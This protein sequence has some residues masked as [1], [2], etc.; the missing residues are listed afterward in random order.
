MQEVNVELTSRHKMY[1]EWQ[2]DTHQY[3]G[4]CTQKGSD[5]Y[6]TYKEQMEGAGEVN[7][8]WKFSQQS[9]SL[10]RQGAIQTKQ[11]FQK[12]ETDRTT[13]HSPHGIFS[14]EINVYKMKRNDENERPSV[15]QISYQLWLNEQYAG[16]H[17]ISLQI[18]WQ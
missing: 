8:V 1:D 6:L 10:L 9:I 5:W 2:E 7:T 11:R 14:M 16:D 18:S 13:Y 17:E 4:R 12:G 3:L 15:I